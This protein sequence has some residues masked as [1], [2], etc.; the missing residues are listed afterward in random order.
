MLRKMIICIPLVCMLSIIWYGCATRPTIKEDTVREEIPAPDVIERQ[1]R[2]AFEEYKEGDLEGAARHFQDFIVQHPRTSLT[3]DALYFLGDIYFQRRE[4]NVA[5][6]QF[7]RLLGY[8]PSSPHYPE[9]QWSLANCY[10]QM[11]R[12][13]D[14][15]KTAVKY[16]SILLDENIKIQPAHE[17]NPKIGKDLWKVMNAA[18]SYDQHQRP[19]AEEFANDLKAWLENRP[20]SYRNGLI[21]RMW[22]R[23]QR[24][25][26]VI[27]PVVVALGLAGGIIANR[28][29]G[30]FDANSAQNETV[31]VQ[32]LS[33]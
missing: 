4:Y 29:S 25:S 6:L 17:L 15:L 2:G 1:F 31:P 13:N 22:R 3:D 11:G 32:K 28:V 12:Y 5:A 27:M 20:V 9:A 33:H 23:F 21:R 19:T 26:K 16:L 18:M 10:Y 14:A 24:N 30:Y 7:E 8:F